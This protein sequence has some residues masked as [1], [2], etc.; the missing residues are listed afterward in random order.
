[1]SIEIPVSFVDQ[2]SA[3]VHMLAEQST[4]RLRG[5]AQEE[6]VEAESFSRDRIGTPQ[7]TANEIMVRHGDTPINDT[8]HSRRWGFIK[9]FDVADLIDRQDRVKLLLDPQGPYTQRHGG[10]MGRSIDDEIIRAALGTVAEG[11]NGDTTVSL[12]SDQR[13][14]SNSG[15]GLT[16]QKLI[17]AKEIMDSSEI[18][19]DMPRF[20]VT[21]ARGI[22]NL[23]EDE[24]VTSADF[25]TIKAL[26]R[27][28]INEFMGFTFIRS[29]RLPIGGKQ[30]DDVGP[31][32][33]S[34]VRKDFAIT[35]GGVILGMAQ[36]P[37]SVATPRPDKRMAQ[38][39]YTWGSWGSLRIEDE[40]VV[41][42]DSDN[43]A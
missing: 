38:Q 40:L 4:S 42:V 15:S 34:D 27:G 43:T 31:D 6:A 10:V 2:F 36:N 14:T 3:S 11:R 16:I 29:E 1:M 37:N 21:S 25:N 5:L 8:P 24:K 26:V 17:D 33:G 18:G 13:L 41:E 39:I 12:P 7:D 19:M 22:S 20:F 35:R 30:K 23:L 9:S 28:E 32:P